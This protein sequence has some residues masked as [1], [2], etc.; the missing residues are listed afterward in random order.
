MNT[1]DLINDLLSLK[2]ISAAQMSRDLG[3]SNGLYSQWKSGLQKPSAKKLEKI[4]EYF[5]VTVD[6]LLGHTDEKNAPSVSIEGA[7]LDRLNQLSDLELDELLNY[8]DY[9]DYKHSRS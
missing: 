4:A 3:F 5:D 9:L 8:L 2:G 1:I 6:Y 7:L